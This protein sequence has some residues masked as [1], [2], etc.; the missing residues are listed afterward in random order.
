MI[1]LFSSACFADVVYLKDGSKVKGQVL[2]MDEDEVKVVLPYGTLA[3]NRADVLRIDLGEGTQPPPQP[4][5]ADAEPREDEEPVKQ[6]TVQEVAPDLELPTLDVKPKNRKSPRSAAM[7]A[8][9]PGGGYGYLERW[10]LAFAAAGVEVGLAALGM[11]MVNDEGE[12]K[13]STGYVVLGF[14]GLLKIAEILDSR[15]RAVKWNE[16]LDSEIGRPLVPDP[17]YPF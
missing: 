10:D 2:S 12:G 17:A 13:N 9:I 14:A 15:D 3:V 11:S 4:G 6:E 1:L 8:V 5:P 16:N 7:L